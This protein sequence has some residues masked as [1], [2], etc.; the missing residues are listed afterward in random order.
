[1]KTT[2]QAMACDVVEALGLGT[3]AGAVEK[4]QARTVQLGEAAR[5]C[6]AAG[7]AD[8][9]FF[10]AQHA[11]ELVSVCETMARWMTMARNGAEAVVAEKAVR[12]S[13][14]AVAEKG[15]AG[16]IEAARKPKATR[17][18]K[19]QPKAQA[20]AQPQTVAPAATLAHPILGM[21]CR[22]AAKELV[23]IGDLAELRNLAV[24]EKR[25]GLAAMLAKRIAR[26]EAKAAKA[27][28]A[29]ST[30]AT[31]AAKPTKATKPTSKKA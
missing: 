7:M 27:A 1:M 16:A 26:L 17:K 21:D 20:P 5:A 22:S 30:K 18:P 13:A 9:E 8:A 25:K 2:T 12:V 24:V 10:A 29:P 11:R 15:L 14:K 28:P 6:K 4:L 31:K 23:G 19:A 3:V